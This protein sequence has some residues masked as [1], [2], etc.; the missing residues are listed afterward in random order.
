MPGK[1]PF[2]KSAFKKHTKNTEDQPGERT[3]RTGHRSED[4]SGP[5]SEDRSGRRPEGRPG[6]RPGNRED[7]RPYA[8]SDARPNTHRDSGKAEPGKAEQD[9]AGRAKPWHDRPARP[10][11][12]ARAPARATEQ[13]QPEGFAA[14]AAQVTQGQDEDAA[15]TLL[16]GVNP[17]LELLRSDPARVDTVFIRKGRHDKRS[18]EIIDICRA[19]GVR[20]ALV[21]D[22]MLEKLLRGHGAHPQNSPRSLQ[23]ALRA[24][25]G[26]L[27]RLYSAGFVELDELLGQVMQAPLPL[28][29]AL[30]QVQ[31]PGNAGTLARTLYALGGAGLVVPRH[32]GV[33]LGSAAAKASAGALARLPVAKPANLG[34]A[35]DAAADLGF[36][37]Y[38]AVMQEEGGPEAESAFAFTPRLPAVLVLGSEEGGIRPGI[39]KRCDKLIYVPM[40]R[41]FNSLN[42]AQAG[43]IILAEMAKN[44]GKLK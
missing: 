4:R 42:V 33:Y 8:H 16:P 10:K 39:A 9:S 19:A 38:G 28:L 3:E 44:S 5:R 34:Q 37:I 7:S 24:C 18:D 36:N 32:N 40:L 13:G 12:P 26:V 15:Q 25:Q 43:A 30:D 11:A 22:Q 14:P 41:D 1:N 2:A 29:L 23:D 21:D 6:N 31:D 27:A 20:F 17:V 35:L